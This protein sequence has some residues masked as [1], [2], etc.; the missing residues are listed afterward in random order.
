M[1]NKK[2]EKKPRRKIFKRFINFLK[3]KITGLNLTK[4]KFNSL[5]LILM[6]IISCVFGLL[7][8][9]A[10]NLGGP[11]EITKSTEIDEVYNNILNNFYEDLDEEE[12]KEAAISGM[13]DYL[14][15]NYSVYYNSDDTNSFNERLSGTYTGIGIEIVANSA[16]KPM[17]NSVF[18]NSPAEKAG[19]KSGDLFMAIDGVNISDYDISDVT[20]LLKNK[21]KTVN[22]TFERDGKQFTKSLT[23]AEIE[24]PSVY[25]KTFEANGKKVGYLELTIFAKNTD[26]QL[27]E[28]LKEL[29]AQG[30]DSLIID[31]RN[32]SG[33]YLDTATNILSLFF[34]KNDVLYQIK[35]K[36]NIEK[37]YDKK[38]STR[39]YPVAVLVNSGSASASEILA[40]AFKELGNSDLIGTKTYGKG[41]VQTVMTLSTG[42]MVKFTTQ[43]WLTSKGNSIDK[44]GIQ[45]TTILEIDQNYY[46]DYTDAKDNQ[47][48]KAIEIL[49]NK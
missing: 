44:V 24:I 15:D 4:D 49:G 42:G 13:V 14:S 34:D 30:I 36:T 18:P 33:G 31:V 48:Q 26:E 23:T 37:Y 6:M 43:E 47:L 25:S 40:S 38:N 3:E 46:T 7:I 1:F 16:S 11:A 10:I 17:V 27:E 29:E 8:A 19:L 20:A 41:T 2:G 5:D 39:S 9:E 21:I 28:K 45:P 32:N 22:I 35:T 12:L